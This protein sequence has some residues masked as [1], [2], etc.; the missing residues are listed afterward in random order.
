VTEYQA[1][2]QR[3]EITMTCHN[4]HVKKVIDTG[5]EDEVRSIDGWIKVQLADGRTFAYCGID[6]LRKG[7]HNLKPKS[8][9]ELV[10][11]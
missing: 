8:S 2:V 3:V 11:G 5:V 6:C 4:C 1:V 9:I 7:S 10:E